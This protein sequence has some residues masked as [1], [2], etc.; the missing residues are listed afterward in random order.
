[1]NAR[2]FRLAVLVSHPIH[3]QAALYR[4]LARHPE[5]E[6]KVFYCSDFGMSAKA[7]PELGRSFNY[8]AGILEGYAYGFLKNI[9]PNPSLSRFS[10]LL[11]AGIIREFKR[12]E[13]DAVLVHGWAYASMWLCFLTCALRGVPLLIRGEATLLRPVPRWKMPFKKTLLA[14]LFKKTGGLLFIGG[15]NRDFYRAYGVPEER[16]FFVPYAVD[17]EHFSEKYGH[18]G[19]KRKSIRDAFGIAGD[20]VVVL[21]VGKLV[22]RKRPFDLLRAFESLEGDKALLFVGE[23][24]QSRSLMEYVGKK[25]IENVYFMGFRSQEE[26][27]EFLSI[28]DI[29]VLPSEHEPWGMVVNEAM[30]FAL[31]VIAADK[32][33]SAKDLVRDGENG[34]V[35]KAGDVEKLS[36][37][38]GRLLKDPGLRKSM[39]MRSRE[40][41]GGWSYKED[42]D[43]I[44]SALRFIKN[45]GS[46]KSS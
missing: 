2:T 22:D 27:P 33:G 5:V 15:H 4:R 26:L 43:G 25:N 31:P 7:D 3:Y 38:L 32:V 46:D 34:Y 42:V 16:L 30:N 11:N 19:A 39:G 6:L 14:S 35:Y 23:G 29:F 36:E 9:S 40:I 41:I 21:F 44:L 37:R 13:F 12:G 45:S 18:Y 17:N 28:A 24:G 1:M 8:G 10:G 20:K